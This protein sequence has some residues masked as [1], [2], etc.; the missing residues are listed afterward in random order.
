MKKRIYFIIVILLFSTACSAE[1]KLEYKEKIFTET[2]IA[3]DKIDENNNE[4]IYEAFGGKNSNFFKKSNGTQYDVSVIKKGDK[5]V[6]TASYKYDG[7]EILKNSKIFD[8]FDHVIYKDEAD[9]YLINAWGDYIKCPYVS[10]IKVEFESDMLILDINA[11]E[12]D[13]DKGIY[14]WKHLDDGIKIQISK[15]YKLNKNLK[16]GSTNVRLIAIAVTILGGAV[17]ILVRKRVNRD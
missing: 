9:Y 5:E 8:C 7:D 4:G 3:T 15:N 11:H 6:L 2:L 10:D 17:Y 16:K 12:L 14:K 13:K 1:Y